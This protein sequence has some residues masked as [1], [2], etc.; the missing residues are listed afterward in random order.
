MSDGNLLGGSRSPFSF[1][2]LHSMYLIHTYIILGTSPNMH[3]SHSQTWKGNFPAIFW[4]TA[5]SSFFL[6][7]FRTMFL[8]LVGLGRN[9][10]FLLQPQKS[11]SQT[12]NHG[13]QPQP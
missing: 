1:P 11:N 9:W 4:M 7:A 10:Y 13:M 3:D 12:P 5:L 6:L 8:C 2:V